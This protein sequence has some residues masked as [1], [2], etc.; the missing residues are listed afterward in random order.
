MRKS[1]AF[2]AVA[3]LSL[4]LGI[5]ANTTIFSL[6]NATLLR[7]LPVADPAGLVYVYSGTAGDPFSR[8]SYPDFADMRDQNQVFEGLAA[9]GG[10]SA[11]LNAADETDT[12]GGAIVTGNYFDVLGV[13]AALGRTITPDDDHTPGAHPV[14]VLGHG[15]WQRRFGGDPGIINRQITLNGQQFTVIGVAPAE[16]GGAEK[17]TTRDL[18]VPMMMQPLMRPPRAGYSGEMNP[19]LLGVRRNRWLLG[20]G[21]LKSGVSV[22]GAQ[23]AMSVIAKQQETAYPDTNAKRIVA[24][25]PLTAGDPTTRGSLVSVAGLLA[26]V[27]GLVLLIACANVAN[28]LL[29]RAAA[30]RKEVALRL[31]LGA[32]RGRLVQQLLTE[33]V[34]LALAGGVVGLALAWWTV[35]LLKATEPPPGLIPIAPDFALDWR[36]MAFTLGLSVLTGIIFG[37]APALRASR[38]DL[39]PALK[40]ESSAPDYKGRMFNLRN[41]L[42]VAQVALSLL[43]LV[44]SGLFLRSLWKAQAIE[45]G[46]AADKILTVPLNINLLRYTKAQ[47]REYYRQAVERVE[48][49]PGVESA[50]LAR[51]VA[52]SGGG[53]IRG[54]LIEG[55]ATQENIMRSESGGGMTVPSSDSV[56]SANVVSQSYLKTMGIPLMR[57][58]DFAASDTEGRPNVVI[59][60]EA[61]ER[62][63]FEGQDALGRRISFGQASG[64]WFEIVGVARDSKYTTLGE[65]PTAHVYVP[66]AQNHETGMTM[67]VR[68]AGDPAGIAA[69]VRRE[70]QTIDR[71]VPVASARPMTELL[72]SSLYGARMGAVLLGAFGLLALLLAGVGLYGVM[73]YTV[74]RRTR[75]IGIRMALGARSGD[76]LGMVMREALALVAA[77]VALG[78]VASFALT[79]LLASFLYG[80][81]TTDAATFAGVPLVLAAVALV[82]GYLP[83][84]R[85]MKVDPMVALRYE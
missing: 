21:R 18:Y 56:V 60:N 30:R 52:L 17:G 69:S 85:A 22:E 37:L 27:V 73:S 12:V 77:G 51:V 80:V 75:E 83:A 11:S 20:I 31:A 36:V 76:V 9:F 29:A 54:L 66:L 59:V 28:L 44:G 38:P 34:L 2:T 43:L 16:F 33:S 4:A 50:S 15:L 63:H 68:A 6:V 47:G 23:T 64:P 25:S 13:R 62:R 41:G 8:L 81:G 1:K 40:D 49:L 78:L 3:V 14:V 39:L 48:S 7:Q 82:A 65:A 42:V 46:F 55:R 45:P 61:F 72:S 84:R 53:S 71:N 67:H 19:D 57:G 24:L 74:A 79:R 58:R 32:S 5:G 10:I 26:A 35:D 70:L